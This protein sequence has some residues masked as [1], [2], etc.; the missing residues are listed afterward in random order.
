MEWSRLDENS[1]NTFAIPDFTGTLMLRAD[2]EKGKDT[3]SVFLL[4]SMDET[5]PVLT[6][7]DPISFADKAT[8]E[9]TFTMPSGK[10]EVKAA[11]VEEVKVGPFDDVATNVY[12]YEAVKWAQEKGITGGIGNSLFGPAPAR[13]SSRSCGARTASKR[14][15]RTASNAAGET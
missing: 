5:P 9:Y 8:G 10:A 11:F 6:L 15:M 1:T 2:G 3:T 14:G 13:R 12:Y 4:V 7:S